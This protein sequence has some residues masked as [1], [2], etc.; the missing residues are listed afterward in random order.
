[1]NEIVENLVGIVAILSAV[2]LPIGLGMYLAIRS[3]NQKH[4]ERMELIKQGLMPP[5]DEKTPPNRLKTLRNAVLL[6]GIGLGLVVG[7]LISKAMYLD[8]DNAFWV[9]APSILFFLGASFL[10][11]FKLSKK[12]EDNQD[13]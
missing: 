13:E 4:K 7:L 8:E 12:Y 6:I 9:V 5:S 10:V 2:A 11:Y 3:N 1:M